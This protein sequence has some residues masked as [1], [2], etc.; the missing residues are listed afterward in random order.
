MKL[1]SAV[2][3]QRSGYVNV[4]VCVLVE[5]FMVKRKIKGFF[6]SPGNVLVYGLLL[7]FNLDFD[8][9][10]VLSFKCMLHACVNMYESVSHSVVSKSFQLHGLQ[11]QLLCPWTSPFKNTGVVCHFLL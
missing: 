4:C 3:S 5:K 1:I 6:W 2:R 8:Y 7:L 9:T 10:D 11:H